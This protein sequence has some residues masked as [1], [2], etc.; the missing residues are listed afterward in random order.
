VSHH[1]GE[2]GNLVRSFNRHGLRHRTAAGQTNQIDSPAVDGISLL[3]VVNDGINEGGVVDCPGI[4]TA[5][6]RAVVESMPPRIWR[7]DDKAAR[8]RHS[9]PVPICDNQ[10]TAWDMEDLPKIRIAAVAFE[11]APGRGAARPVNLNNARSRLHHGSF[12]LRGA[13]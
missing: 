12:L 11:L 2:S 1:G 9:I 6:T 3:H 8:F 10:L 13:M 7:C 5:A 4:S